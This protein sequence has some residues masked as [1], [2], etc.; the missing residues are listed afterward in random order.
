MEAVQPGIRCEC[1]GRVLGKVYTDCGFCERRT[2]STRCIRDAVKLVAVPVSPIEPGVIRISNWE[3]YV[4][5][6]A[7]CAEHH[8]LMEEVR[9]GGGAGPVRG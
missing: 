4:P 2:D 1:P 8:E 3:L 6:C 7:P 9:D 5:L